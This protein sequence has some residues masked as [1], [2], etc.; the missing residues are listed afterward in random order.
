L[1]QPHN[2]GL[3]PGGDSHAVGHP[4]DHASDRG[5]NESDN[6]GR[7]RPRFSTIPPFR[8][9]LVRYRFLN[10]PG[11][12][13]TSS[14]HRAFSPGSSVCSTSMRSD[15]ACL[16]AL[17]SASEKDRLL[18]HA[19]AIQTLEG[20]LRSAASTPSGACVMPG[21]PPMI[22]QTGTGATGI[23]ALGNSMLSGCDYYMATDP[24]SHPHQVVGRLH[25]SMSKA[26]FLATIRGLPHSAG[27]LRR[28]G[29]SFPPRSTGPR[30]RVTRSRARTIRL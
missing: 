2:Y 20:T 17:V 5:A 19:D 3:G 24:T 12:D 28:A 4:L 1:E 18:A 8:S 9:S 29:S 7:A 27:R 14:R 26:A 21:M 16:K 22:P 11:L 10:D 25:L 23:C 15:L 13:A 30:S 6:R